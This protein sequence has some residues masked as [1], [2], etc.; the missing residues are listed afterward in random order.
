MKAKKQNKD[1]DKKDRNMKHKAPEK[2]RSWSMYQVD[3][4][5]NSRNTGYQVEGDKEIQRNKITL[6]CKQKQKNKDKD[7]QLLCF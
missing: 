3:I 7:A 1:F 4:E 5:W 6:S 2:S